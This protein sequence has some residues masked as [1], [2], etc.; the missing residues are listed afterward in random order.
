MNPLIHDQFLLHNKIA[1]RLYHE[2]AKPMPIVDYHC[3]VAV[4]QINQNHQFTN[5]QEAWLATDQFK[6]RAMRINGIAERFCSGNASP[7]EK[8]QAWAET[9]PKTLSNP[10]FHWTHLE[11]ARY[12]GIDKVLLNGDTAEEIW[13]ETNRQLQSP[14]YTVQGLFRKM[15]VKA[16][17]TT[18]D[19]LDDLAL[20]RSLENQTSGGIVVRPTFRPDR[21]L[22]VENVEKFNAW[23]DQLGKL[24]GKRLGT[25]QEFLNALAKRHDFFHSMGCRQAHHAIETMFCADYSDQKTSLIYGE[26]RAGN[27]LNDKKIAQFRTAVLRELCILNHQRGWVQQFHIGVMRNSNSRMAAAYGADIGFDAITDKHYAK[28]L[29][30]FLD[31]LDS[32]NQL[33]KT[34]LYGFNPKDQD[35]LAAMSSAF[36]DG[37]QPGKI[38]CGAGWWFQGQKRSIE[39]QID[40]LANMSLLSHFIGISSGTRSVLSYPRHEYFRRVLCNLLGQDMEQGLIPMDFA[41]IGQVVQD[42][43]YHNANRYFALGI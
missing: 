17:C 29:A 7:R 21:A 43:C 18:D 15:N 35:M 14:D 4:S 10:L 2:Y 3:H 27:P 8:F 22:A 33:T 41:W 38:Q 13:Q 36:Q 1:E 25:Y 9:V 37:S 19:P 40:S 30:N 5:I 12:F 23:V 16:V 26:I 28:K 20:H 39:Q 42:I 31:H 24:V 11:L 32:H 6:W 34:I